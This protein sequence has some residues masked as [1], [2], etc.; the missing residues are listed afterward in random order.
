LP[1]EWNWLDEYGENDDAKLV[2]YTN[3]IPGF[4]HYA[5]AP[6]AKEWHEYAKAVNRGMA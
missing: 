1:R 3:G 2:H 6:H 5:E 4:R